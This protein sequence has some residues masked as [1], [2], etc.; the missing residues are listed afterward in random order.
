MK[1]MK[2]L[3]KKFYIII[4]ISVF[5]IAAFIIRERNLRINQKIGNVPIYY[6]IG[7]VKEIET[8]Y[9]YVDVEKIKSEGSEVVV[10][11]NMCINIKKST[12]DNVKKDEKVEIFTF[13]NPRQKD[14]ISAYRI[15]NIENRL[16]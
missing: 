8:D 5:L 9:I 12:M 11:L 14:C 16:K 7:T 1:K 4:G 10:S 6:L 15:T 2:K 3:K 13:D